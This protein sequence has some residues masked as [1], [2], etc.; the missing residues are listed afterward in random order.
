M[1]E[2]FPFPIS[3]NPRLTLFSHERDFRLPSS[4]VRVA[5]GEGVLQLHPE[6]Q[7]LPPRITICTVLASF[8]LS[9]NEI[10]N[11]VH[12]STLTTK[13]QLDEARH[14]LQL[15]NRASISRHYLQTGYYSLAQPIAP[16]LS[17]AEKLV[18]DGTSW[19]LTNR[20]VAAELGLS[21]LTVK[22]HL[23]RISDRTGWLGRERIT[24]AAFMSEEISAL[25]AAGLAD[26]EPVQ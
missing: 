10:A 14:R 16:F 22:S 7:P 4:L 2:L 21:H 20:E 15:L 8:G 11:A 5:V 25:P 13:T 26:I 9:N 1:Q 24:L 18:V 12:N 3:N 17:D 23:A 19:G 6:K